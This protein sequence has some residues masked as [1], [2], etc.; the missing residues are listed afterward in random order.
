VVLAAMPF[1]S[2]LI[3]VVLAIGGALFDDRRAR[4]SLDA[5]ASAQGHEILDARRAYPWEAPYMYLRGSRLITWRVTVRGHAGQVR[6]GLV[7]FMFTF[8]GIRRPTQVDVKWDNDA[9]RRSSS[10]ADSNQ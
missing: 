7:T 9:E 10:V 8:P 3:V 1:W 6:T 4:R 2:L 5:W